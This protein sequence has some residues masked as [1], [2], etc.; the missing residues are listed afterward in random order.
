MLVK[1]YFL[2]YLNCQGMLCERTQDRFLYEARSYGVP[3]LFV[4]KKTGGSMVKNPHAKEETQVQSLIQE[5][6]L[7]KE[8]AAHSSI[9]AWK[10][11]WTEKPGEL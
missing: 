5:D 4:F 11:P 7:K 10:I 1:S 8:M 6:S 9:I 2:V 3:T